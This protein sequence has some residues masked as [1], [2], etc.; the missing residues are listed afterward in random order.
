MKILFTS[1]AIE[2]LNTK[3]KNVYDTKKKNGF[4][5]FLVNHN[6]EMQVLRM[7]LLMLEHVV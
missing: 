7:I 5:F 1:F 3:K 6:D 2:A 4:L